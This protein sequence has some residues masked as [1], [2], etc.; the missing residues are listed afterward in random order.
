MA[1]LRSWSLSIL[2]EV[3]L[4]SHLPTWFHTR[5]ENP[6][7]VYLIW[8]RSSVAWI[9]PSQHC[10]FFTKINLKSAYHDEHKCPSRCGSSSIS[11]L[12]SWKWP[13]KHSMRNNV[14]PFTIEIPW[15]FQLQLFVNQ[16]NLASLISQSEE[17]SDGFRLFPSLSV[18]TLTSTSSVEVKWDIKD[19]SL[20]K[21]K[22]QFKVGGL[23]VDRILIEE[24]LP[25]RP[26]FLALITI[27]YF[28]TQTCMEVS[29]FPF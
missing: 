24:T 10:Q 20:S 14:S 3:S 12:S 11:L 1:L 16:S 21:I 9:L 7:S 18:S 28:Y 26:F 25:C 2:Q 22:D 27:G 13:Q 6:R 29:S 5:E 17:F 15:W 4:Y 8:I 19:H 23:Y